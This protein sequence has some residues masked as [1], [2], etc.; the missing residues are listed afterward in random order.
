M[1]TI[2][3]EAERAEI[4]KALADYDLHMLSL[5]DGS[6]SFNLAQLRHAWKH[7]NEGRVVAGK[8]V[9]ASVIRSMEHHKSND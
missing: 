2:N 6:E 4:M 8:E 7:L 1:L 5:L 3:N 9:L